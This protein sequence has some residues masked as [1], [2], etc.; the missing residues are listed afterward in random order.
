MTFFCP[1]FKPPKQIIIIGTPIHEPRDCSGMSL[2]EIRF[3]QRRPTSMLLIRGRLPWLNYK[4]PVPCRFGVFAF[5]I[6]KRN[7]QFA[8]IADFGKK[9]TI[10]ENW[11]VFRILT[12]FVSWAEFRIM[13]VWL[14]LYSEI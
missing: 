3:D 13:Q 8:L 7:M 5:M 14:N 6:S 12:N 2:G 10:G 4:A 9:V 1:P 11:K